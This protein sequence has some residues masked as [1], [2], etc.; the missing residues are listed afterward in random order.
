MKTTRKLISILLAIICCFSIAVPSIATN[1]EEP[2]IMPRYQYLSIITWGFEVES[3]CVGSVSGSLTTYELYNCQIKANVQIKENGVWKSYD[4][5]SRN[6]TDGT[7]GLDEHCA[8]RSGYVYRCRFTFVVYDDNG[9]II[10]NVTK[11]SDEVYC[12]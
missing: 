9:T 6:D 7:V 2:I 10:E 5:F 3:F 11:Y 12:D 1:A 4:S 8:L